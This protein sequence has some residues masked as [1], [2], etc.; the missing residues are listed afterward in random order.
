MSWVQKFLHPGPEPEVVEELRKKD[1]QLE[2][3]IDRLY[4]ILG[5]EREALSGELREQS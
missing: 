5:V 2:K 3:K 1:K 4:D